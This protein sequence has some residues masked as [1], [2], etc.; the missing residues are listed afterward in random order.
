MTDTTEPKDNGPLTQYEHL[1]EIEDALTLLDIKEKFI[2]EEIRFLRREAIRAHDEVLTI[3]SVPLKVG[4]FV[5]MVDPNYAYIEGDQLVRVMKAIDRKLLK[6]NTSV[7]LHR[8]SKAIVDILPPEGTT[9]VQILEEKPDVCY[10]DIGG[11][12]MQKQELKEA[13]ELPLTHA[14]LY[15]QIGIDPP[16]GV[17]LYGPPGTGKTMLAKAVAHHTCASFISLAAPEFVQKYLGDGPK[18]VRDTFALAREHSPAIVFI[19]EIDSIAQKRFDA[20]GG[21]DRE[22][23]RILMELLT[24]MDGFEQ[25]STVKVI[26]A[27]NRPET[28]DPALLRPGRLDRKIEFPLPDRRQKRLIFQVITKNMSL[29]PDIDLEDY[30]S[31]PDKI[32]GAEISAICM[33]AGM[34]AVRRNRYVVLP[35]DFELAYEKIVHKPDPVMSCYN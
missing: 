30:V 29:S 24:Q 10:A 27:T 2:S 35:K 31:R 20:E 28:L 18:M 13:V 25:N 3:Q 7:A 11:L 23:Q 6:P 8:H 26:M 19:D 12:D 14:D 17:L 21:A 33:E 9:A 5:E 15:K 34:Q 16:R 32:S 1:K 22:I 4:N